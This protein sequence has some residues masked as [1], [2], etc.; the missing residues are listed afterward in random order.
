MRAWQAHFV[1]EFHYLWAKRRTMQKICPLPYRGQNAIRCNILHRIY[2]SRTGSLLTM[3]IVWP[4]LRVV[5]Q[6]KICHTQKPFTG[7]I[8]ETFQ[9]NHNE[10]YRRKQKQFAL[11]IVSFFYCSGRQCIGMVNYVFFVCFGITPDKLFGIEL[12]KIMICLPW[13]T[14]QFTKLYFISSYCIVAFSP[15][16]TSSNLFLNEIKALQPFQI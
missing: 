8:S 11:T 3:P 9:P 6:L 10:H 1:K 7:A 4:G 16:V 5:C 12:F 13:P 15:Q 14:L 2:L